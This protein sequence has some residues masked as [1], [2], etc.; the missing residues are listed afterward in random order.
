MHKCKWVWALAWMLLGWMP[1]A[2][3]AE[4]EPTIELIRTQQRYPWNNL[5]DIDYT[6]ANVPNPNDYYV[7]FNVITN[8]IEPGVVATTFLDDAT[9]LRA[10]NGTYRVTW[11]PE[12]DRAYICSR[13]VTVRAELIYDPGCNGART[14]Y[15]KFSYLVVDLTGGNN[16]SYAMEGFTTQEEANE[17]Y[18]TST[19]KT[20]KLVLRR[21]RA[22]K[23]TM[24]SPDTETGRASQNWMN[25]ETQHTVTLTKDYFIG[26]FP[27]T[28]KQWQL[29][30]GSRP[31]NTT[32]YSDE[33]PVG[34]V[35][36]PDIRGSSLGIKVP[37]DGQVDP[38]SFLDVLRNRTG[39]VG[40]DLPT[41]AQWECACRAGTTTS[42]Y[43]GDNV[44][45]NVDLLSQYVWCSGVPGASASSKS[46][47]QKKPNPWGLYDTLGHVWEWCRDRTAPAPAHDNGSAPVTDPLSQVENGNHPA[48]GGDDV[49][50]A[51]AARAAA[52]C[53]DQTL[54]RKAINFGF[55]LVCEMP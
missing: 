48:R 46:V 3:L 4:G 44:T 8:G 22:C 37:I 40:F 19:Y 35:S 36:Y 52:C 6:V 43:F 16:F 45:E 55:R 18:N 13:D 10:S 25:K 42:T 21:I 29:I 32:G 5:V 39:L 9:L 51:F 34:C 17:K 54:D 15:T 1:S 26:V 24:G 2:V 50:G 27:V 38:E 20:E 7:Q 30:K 49:T 28:M 23:F 53:G 12:L 14:P 47:G 31:A 33:R 11:N 41:E